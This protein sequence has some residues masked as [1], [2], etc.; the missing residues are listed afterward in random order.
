MEVH[1]QPR[2]RV[3][4][5]APGAGL[6]DGWSALPVPERALHRSRVRLVAHHGRWYHWPTAAPRVAADA[7]TSAVRGWR[8]RDPGAPPADRGARAGSDPAARTTSGS[9]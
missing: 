9:L 4:Y 3:L 2:S 5:D 6:G 8:R 1:Y 7:T